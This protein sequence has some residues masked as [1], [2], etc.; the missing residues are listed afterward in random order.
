[1]LLLHG[2]ALLIEGLW[3]WL[4]GLG[5]VAIVLYVAWRSVEWGKRN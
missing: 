4:G 3:K 2:E 1:M 5:L